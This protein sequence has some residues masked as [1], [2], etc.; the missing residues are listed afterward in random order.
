MKE[1]LKSQNTTFIA[2]VD[3]NNMPHASYSPYV[4]IEDKMY[5]YISK[6]AEHYQNLENNKNISLMIAE[7]ECKSKVLFARK[8]ISFKGEATKVS[9]VDSKVKEKFEEIHTKNMM[10][11][12]YTM[13]F[14][15]FEIKLLEG[16]LVEGFGKAYKL[17]Y[18]NNDWES[19]H[20]VIDKPH[21][22]SEGHSSHNPH[23]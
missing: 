18:N 13:D 3:N 16:R 10:D 5:I 2:S 19:E 8:R 23:K 6:V 11:V 7:D 20:I 15:F 4:M 1:F 12:L 22:A 21:N 9:D 14:D 17:V